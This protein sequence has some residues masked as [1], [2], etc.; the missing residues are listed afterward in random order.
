MLI[1]DRCGCSKS[2]MRRSR[3][4][5]VKQKLIGVPS[6]HGFESPSSWISRAALSQGVRVGELLHYFGVARVGDFDMGLSQKKAQ[7]IADTCGISIIHFDFSLKMFSTLRSIDRT[8]RNFLLPFDERY[9]RYRYCPG[10][11]HHQRVKHFPLHWRFKTWRF[12]P[13]HQ[14]LMEDRCLHC[15]SNII[16][17]ADMFHSGPQK[18]GIAF[19]DRCLRC[20]KKL[21]THWEKVQGLTAEDLLDDEAMHQLLVGRFVLS[22]LYHGHFFMKKSDRITKRKLSEI[23]G[24]M[25]F[26]GTDKDWVG[27]DNRELLR[28]RTA[29]AGYPLD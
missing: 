29:R 11:L 17:S 8:G 27:I 21:S 9:G 7:V 28:R 6:P 19:L 4:S 3:V 12:C 5:E 10:C 16:L 1:G 23:L 26:G 22:A 18:K 2:K 15:G 25:H 20:E 24:L 13:I 14:C